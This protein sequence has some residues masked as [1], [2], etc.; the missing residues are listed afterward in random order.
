MSSLLLRRVFQLCL[1]VHPAFGKM[2]KGI[3][4]MNTLVLLFVVSI[5]IIIIVVVVVV[6][7][8]VVIVIIVISF[9]GFLTIQ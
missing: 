3:I 2:R 9:W 8:V 4:T 1:R 6:V 7:V 5:Y